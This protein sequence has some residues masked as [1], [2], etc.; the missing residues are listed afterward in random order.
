[1]NWTIGNGKIGKEIKKGIFRG[2][3]RVGE[4]YF[5]RYVFDPETF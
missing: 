4:V 1:M 3:G 2:G 5:Q